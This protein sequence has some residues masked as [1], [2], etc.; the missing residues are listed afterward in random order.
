[1]L[2]VAGV[3]SI[4]TVSKVSVKTGGSISVPCLYESWHKD[5][6][7][8][9]C[10]GYAWLSCKYAAKTDRPSGSGKFSISDDRQQGIFT[11]TV[12]NVTE[13]DTWYWCAVE[14]KDGPDDGEYFQVL[15]TRDQNPQD[16][17]GLYVDH[18]EITGFKGDN[19]SIH[20]HYRVSGKSQWCRLGE[21]CVEEPSGSISGTRVTIRENFSSVFTV[22]LIG[23]R[24]ESSGWY[25][26]VKGDLQMP[27]HVTV[28]DRLST[29]KP[30]ATTHLT[31]FSHTLEPVTDTTTLT[32][33]AS[34][35][36]Q[37]GNHSASVYPLS[38]IIILLILLIVVTT[39]SFIWCKLKRRTRPSAA[40]TRSK[41]EGDVEIVYSAVTI[42]PQPVRK[43]VE[44]EDEE[45]TYST[46]AQ[47]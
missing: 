20:C 35:T 22:T 36:V 13:K 29:V 1:M 9:L 18:Q 19:V 12:N 32:Y 33:E 2:L 39:A 3:Y 45:V 30:T 31:P 42:N 25:L 5:R 46:L 40:S 7:K 17:P 26:C 10:E 37:R 38:F 14:I 41:A 28:T 11:V 21:P 34:T 6:V 23:L 27:V 24:T 44:A 43:Q 47:K 16:S 4:T 8:Y 15:T